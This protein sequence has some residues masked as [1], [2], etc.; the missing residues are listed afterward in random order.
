MQ[1]WRVHSTHSDIV[2]LT[3][4]PMVEHRSSLNIGVLASGGVCMFGRWSGTV[5]A[6]GELIQV[7]DLAGWAEEF[8]H[9]W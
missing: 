3:F 2:R 5:R 9:R 7:A 4:Q 1:P 8:A 6:G